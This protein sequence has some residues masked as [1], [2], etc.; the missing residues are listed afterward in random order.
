[1]VVSMTSSAVQQDSCFKAVVLLHRWTT[2]LALHGWNFRG[3]IEAKTEKTEELPRSPS[4]AK[5]IQQLAWLHGQ[6]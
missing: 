4:G 3:E 1:M 6:P 5:N 2:R